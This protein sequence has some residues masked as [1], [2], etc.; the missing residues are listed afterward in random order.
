MNNET[1]LIHSMEQKDR[2]RKQIIKL[3]NEIAKEKIELLKINKINTENTEKIIGLL[4]ENLIQ[5]KKYMVK[6]I[7]EEHLF[8]NEY[9]EAFYNRL[10]NLDLEN[11]KEF[12]EKIKYYFEVFS[13][14]ALMETSLLLETTI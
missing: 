7:L 13:A 14:R 11:K 5:N 10:I 1:I 9:T 2:H 6:Q 8:F 12:I 3:K 4:N